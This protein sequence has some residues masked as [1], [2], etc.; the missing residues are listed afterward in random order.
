MQYQLEARKD[1]NQKDLFWLEQKSQ[2]LLTKQAWSSDMNSLDSRNI[3]W[4]ITKENLKTM[5]CVQY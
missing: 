1:K 2:K 4:G 3:N 5:I